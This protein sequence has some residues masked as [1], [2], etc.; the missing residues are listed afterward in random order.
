MITL[1]IMTVFGYMTA[2]FILSIVL[3]RNDFVDVAWGLGFVVLSWTMYI[4]RSSLQ[5]SLAVLLSTLWGLRIATHIFLRNIKKTE[6]FRYLQWRKDWGKWF[7]LRSYFQIY[8]L[9]GLFM[10]IISAPIIFLGV[11]G[12]DTLLP[13]HFVAV[14]LW[15]IGFF[16]EA[17]G[18]YELGQFI[19]NPKNKGEVMQEGLWRYTRHPNYFGEV[20]QWWAIWLISFGSPWFIYAIVGPLTITVLI[21]KVSGVPLLE[22]K[23]KG[24]KKFE[25][26]KKQTSIFFPLPPKKSSKRSV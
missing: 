10:L 3:K 20:T 21:L 22:K 18:D 8:M 23:Y 26:Y 17:V 15:S 4:S 1:A 11:N 5:L 19:K 25:A 2:W 16:F 12:A 7:L 6:D 24:N 14:A 13:I 9:Q